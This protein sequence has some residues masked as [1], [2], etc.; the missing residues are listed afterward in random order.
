MRQA[1]RDAVQRAREYAEALGARLVAL[2]ELA[3]E[4]VQQSAPFRAR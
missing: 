1:V 2:V 3:D 4:G